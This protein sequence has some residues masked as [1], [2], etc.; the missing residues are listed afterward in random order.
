MNDPI[1]FEKEFKKLDSGEFTFFSK[2]LSGYRNSLMA[3]GFT[4]REAMRLVEAYSKFI[5][6][7]SLEDY[8]SRNRREELEQ[9]LELDQDFDDDDVDPE[10]E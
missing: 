3:E 10:D 8:I 9:E 7:M 4:R 1:D 6:D 2:A 5:Y